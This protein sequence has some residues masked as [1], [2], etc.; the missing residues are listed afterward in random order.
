MSRRRHGER[1]SPISWFNQRFGASAPFSDPEGGKGIWTPFTRAPA[2][3]V[4]RYQVRL[5]GV[6]A[7][8]WRV[9]LLADLHVG[10]HAEDVARLG[11]IVR[12]TNALGPDLVLLLGD[13]MNMMPL[14]RGRVPPETI[15]GILAGLVA[16]AGVLGVLGNHD[17]EY[18]RDAVARAFADN[19]LALVD[20]RIVVVE[21]D[22]DRLAVLGL[23]DDRRGEPDLALFE[24]LPKGLPAL[25][26]THDPGLFHDMPG[27]HVVVAG[28]MHG[29][30]IRWPGLPA[31]VVPSGR[32]PRRWANGRIEEGGSTLIVS[33]GLGASGLPWRFGIPPEIVLL[34]L[35]GPE[36]PSGTGA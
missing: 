5:D 16:P 3:H 6:G 30:Q 24:R 21:R 7:R 15:A 35:V 8:S 34:E 18:G 19:G 28:H 2:H 23:D 33:A 25:V 22:G 32:A 11:S 9:A 4:A 10:G 20:N 17:W 29:G 14:G 27:G 26:A 36:I 13:Y 1:V 31:L 12:D